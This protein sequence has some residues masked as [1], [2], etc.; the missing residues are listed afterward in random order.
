[1]TRPLNEFVVFG[2]CGGGD[3]DLAAFLGIFSSFEPVMAG[4]AT[5]NP[6]ARNN[7][8]ALV[9]TPA[10]WNL[11]G[12]VCGVGPENAS[13]GLTTVFPFVVFLLAILLKPR[14]PENTFLIYLVHYR[15]INRLLRFCQN[16]PI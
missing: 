14:L 2:A 15:S 7:D 8:T 4:A 11:V 12:E 10:S 6:V 13:T 16:V 9:T 1:M 5:Y 3:K